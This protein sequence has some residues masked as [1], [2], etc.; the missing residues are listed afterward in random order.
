LNGKAHFYYTVP[1]RMQAAVPE[2]VFC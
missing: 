2:A 1:S